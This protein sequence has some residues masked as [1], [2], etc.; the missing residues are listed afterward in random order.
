MGILVHVLCRSCPVC[1]FVA[2]L[3]AAPLGWGL[4]AFVAMK[5]SAQ[6]LNSCCDRE[7]CVRVSSL[8]LG[9]NTEA[10]WLSTDADSYGGAQGFSLDMS[11]CLGTN[12]VARGLKLGMPYCVAEQTS[13]GTCNLWARKKDLRLNWNMGFEGT[14]SC[15]IVPVDGLDTGAVAISFFLSLEGIKTAA[16]P[17]NRVENAIAVRKSR[18]DRTTMEDIVWKDNQAGICL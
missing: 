11:C 4:V 12:S 1:S 5:G 2:M 3:T 7:R 16:P 9:T 10:L 13:G 17:R 14:R 8:G 18:Q 6:G 15:M